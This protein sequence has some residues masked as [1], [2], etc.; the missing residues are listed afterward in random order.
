MIEST[1]EIL[2]EFLRMPLGNSKQVFDKFRTLTNA[3]HEGRG[4][5]QFLYREG[6]RK[7]KVLLVAHADT[8]WDQHHGRH[9]NKHHEVRE[10]EGKLATSQVGLGADDRAGCA[11]LWLLRDSGHSLLITDGEEKKLQGAT[12]IRDYHSDLLD[13][14]N[15]IHQFVVEFDRKN[16]GEFKCYTVGTPDFVKYIRHQTKYCEK[17]DCGSTDISV[18]CMH[19]C[20]VNLSIGYQNEHSADEH[21]TLADWEHTLNLTCKWLEHEELPR[22]K[23]PHS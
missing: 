20:G 4:S 10:E 13:N 19:I 5:K 7:N 14:I 2:M 17:K 23:L 15:K 8:Y 6:N 9:S 18:L 12:W 3:K 22:F 16:A 21:L 11:I 1:K